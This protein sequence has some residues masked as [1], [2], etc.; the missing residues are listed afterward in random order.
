MANP[1]TLIPGSTFFRVNYFDDDLLIPDV[2]TL[3][4]DSKLSDDSGNDLWLFREPGQDESDEQDEVI[5]VG[6]G[7]SDLY[8][9]L[10]YAELT[11]VIDELQQVIAASAPQGGLA[12]QGAFAPDLTSIEIRICEWEKQQKR[13][14][15]IAARY[16]DDGLFVQMKDGAETASSVHPPAS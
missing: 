5:R 7:E 15:H 3:I 4:F 9:L 6:F 14:L 8:K 16:T 13:S 11:R 2:Q 1:R 10:N 12:P